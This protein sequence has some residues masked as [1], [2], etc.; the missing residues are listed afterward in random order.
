MYPFFVVVFQ[1]EDGSQ[2]L[3]SSTLSSCRTWKK[4]ANIKIRKHYPL[5]P[6]LS[7][8][9]FDLKHSPREGLSKIIDNLPL[10]QFP[11]KLSLVIVAT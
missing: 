7:Q 2:G 11:L 8:H 10:K 9:S 4:I 3:S 6:V 5:L 1:K